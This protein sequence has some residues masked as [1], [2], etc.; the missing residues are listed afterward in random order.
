MVPS[1]TLEIL[2]RSLDI[3]VIQNQP[4]VGIELKVSGS[5]TELVNLSARP[6]KNGRQ[7]DKNLNPYL[8]ST[9]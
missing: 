3:K 2:K 6:R 8:S 7:I 1:L 9:P 5:K 4:V